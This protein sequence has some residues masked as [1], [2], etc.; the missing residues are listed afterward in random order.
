MLALDERRHDGQPPRRHRVHGRALRRRAGRRPARGRPGRRV[1]RRPG[2]AGTP[3]R[4]TP[5]PLIP[6]SATPVPAF[7]L[8]N[9]PRPKSPVP[10]AYVKIA[11]GCDRKCGFCAIPSF[12]GKQRS[13]DVAQILAEVDE[14]AASRRSSSS[15][16]TWR[17]TARTALDELGA[18]AIVPLVRAVGERVPRVRLLYL[19]PS[20][21]SDE[22]IDVV[23]RVERAVLRPV[24]AA[25]QQAAAA[26]DAPLGRRRSIPAPHRRRS[27]P[28]APTPPS[29]A[30]SSSATRARPRT[31][32]TSCF[33]SSQRCPT[34]LVRVLRLQPR[35]RHL[36]RRARRPG[37]RWPRRRAARRAAASCRT[38][39]PRRAPRRV[40][41]HVRRGAR[42]PSGHRPR[43]TGRRRRSTASCSSIRRSPPGRSPRWRSPTPSA[44]TSSPPAPTCRRS[45]QTLDAL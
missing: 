6:V 44:A 13:R 34:R 17:R 27:V 10:W 23:C 45:A 2:A 42:R 11:E 14:L 21:L 8:L 7:D 30:T 20:D 41:R 22:L 39:S 16:R 37:S 31:T 15:P 33:A 18:G 5:G 32:T 29:A 3:V 35:G 26:A 12:R 19:Y 43:A 28:G 25:R 40:D 1:R 9:L 36:R 4:D 38:P 24:A